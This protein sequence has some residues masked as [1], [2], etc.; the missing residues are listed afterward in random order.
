VKWAE[1]GE[2]ILYPEQPDELVAISGE[3]LDYLEKVA[4]SSGR[5]R[6]R[7]CAHTSVEAVI[8]EMVIYHPK[9]TYVHPHKHLN[10]DE[11]F[12]LICGEIDLVM[13]DEGG[14]VVDVLPMGGHAS[15]KAFFYRVSSGIFHTQLFREDTIFHEVTK[16]PFDKK[17]TIVADWAPDEKNPALVE[18]YLGKIRER[19]NNIN[20]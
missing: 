12:H 14:N 5:R 10:K 19:I 3:D 6:S 2:G 11:S 8:H 15:G 4:R 20:S 1:E 16:G 13:F 18:E 9:E 17:D 7:I